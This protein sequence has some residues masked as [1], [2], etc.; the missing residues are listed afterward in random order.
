MLCQQNTVQCL[1]ELGGFCNGYLALGKVTLGG[2]S[3]RG[4]KSTFC[5]SE[6]LIYKLGCGLSSEVF[7]PGGYKVG[8]WEM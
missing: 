8:R 4:L 2:S 7:C 1:C 5:R 3:S 6:N